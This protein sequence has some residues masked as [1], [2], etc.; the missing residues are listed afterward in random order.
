MVFLLGGVRHDRN[1]YVVYRCIAGRGEQLNA[2]PV[3]NCRMRPRIVILG[4][5]FGG[6]YA[7]RE[8]RGGAADGTRLAPRHLYLFQ[9]LLYQVA[10]A[11][12]NPS[13]IAAP[14]RSILRRQKN[15]SVILGEALS[16]DVNARI[17]KLA[18]GE[19]AY[20]YLIVA[21]GATHSYFAHPEWER[22]APGLK[23]IED[24]LEIRRRVLLAFE[25]AERVT[26][27]DRQSA[28]LT[29][30]VLCAGA[31]SAPSRKPSARPIPTRSARGSPSSSSAPAPPARSSPARSP[32][33]HGRRWSA[34]S[35]ASTRRARA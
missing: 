11:A 20:D 14:I 31:S 22:H 12:L 23:T 4:G 32:R 7:A 16:I 28:W 21:T 9:P 29:F 26:D 33:S 8:L 5:G 10:T 3:H 30:V 18:D 27:P 25:E 1:E 17:V 15:V 34:T 24:A 2:F 35:G 13:D 19:V 6:L